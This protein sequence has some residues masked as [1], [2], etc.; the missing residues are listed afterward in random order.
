[1]KHKEAICER[2]KFDHNEGC[3]RLPFCTLETLLE[4]LE[5][6]QKTFDDM[7][8]FAHRHDIEK[9]IDGYQECVYLFET[10]LKRIKDNVE[11]VAQAK[12]YTQY[13]ELQEKLIR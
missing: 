3:T 12:D 10:D 8:E 6:V 2:C 11:L 7:I 4:D 9:S 5:L 13:N 1:M